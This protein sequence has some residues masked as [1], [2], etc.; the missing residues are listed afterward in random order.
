MLPIF[1]ATTFFV[2]VAIS[3]VSASIPRIIA[4]NDISVPGLD[5]VARFDPISS[6]LNL[7]GDRTRVV[8]IPQTD[9]ILA[10]H[11]SYFDN[12]L[13]LSEICHRI[14]DVVEGR[15]SEIEVSRSRLLEAGCELRRGLIVRRVVASTVCIFALGG[16]GTLSQALDGAF[17]K[18]LLWATSCVLIAGVTFLV[19]YK[20]LHQMTILGGFDDYSYAAEMGVLRRGRSSAGWAACEGFIGLL[21]L[22]WSATDLSGL[23]IEADTAVLWS[24]V[25]PFAMLAGLI[26]LGASF[27]SAF[28]YSWAT[29]LAVAG[30]MLT[31]VVFVAT[32]HSFPILLNTFISISVIM[33]VALV[34]R[35][36]QELPG[37]PL[38]ARTE[39][40]WG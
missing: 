40:N 33:V 29:L 30:V 25:S 12:G 20:F 36:S 18:M 23:R 21:M 6:A 32:P 8:V 37:S 19:K 4:E 7:L 22:N 15:S 2:L 5:L 38:S 35:L 28:G 3:F 31:V 13:V 9:S 1:V 10:D 16:I 11:T 39:R 24:T 14:E 27:G 34:R 26:L 17:S